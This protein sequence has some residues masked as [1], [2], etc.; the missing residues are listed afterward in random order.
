MTSHLTTHILDAVTG[1]PAAAVTV[2]LT[3]ASGEV[4]ASGL[5]NEDGRLA[6]GPET[7]PSGNYTLSFDTG[8]YFASAGTEAFY[9]SVTIAFTVGDLPHYHV[10]LLLSPFAYSTYRGS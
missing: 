7:L 3:S 4:V 2:T 9:P 5:T 8:A 6:L 10:P 1:T